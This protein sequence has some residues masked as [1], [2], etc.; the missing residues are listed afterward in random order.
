M[1]LADQ[2]ADQK[3]AISQFTINSNP[4]NTKKYAPGRKSTSRIVT[5]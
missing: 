4:E 1:Y 2:L 5:G 3:H